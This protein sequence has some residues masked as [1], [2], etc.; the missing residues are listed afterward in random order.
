MIRNLQVP[1]FDKQTGLITV[2]VVQSP[3]EMIGLPGGNILMV[4][5]ATEEAY[6]LTLATGFA[7]FWSRS[8]KKIWKKGETSGNLIPVYKILMDCD[9]DT[10]I[11]YTN[12]NLESFSA[13]HRGIVSCFGKTPES[14]CG[15]CQ[16]YEVHSNFNED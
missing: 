9:R 11:Y 12:V 16:E 8:R 6:C 10:V 3:R 1:S 13:C 7:Y 5:H 4:A 15:P 2:V 14:L